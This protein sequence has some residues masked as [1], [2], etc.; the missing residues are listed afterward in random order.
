MAWSSE[1]LRDGRGDGGRESRDDH[2][3][4]VA[5]ALSHVAGCSGGLSGVVCSWC[6]EVALVFVP[7]TSAALS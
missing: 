7:A 2:P 1:A 5:R 3:H 6:L 4:V